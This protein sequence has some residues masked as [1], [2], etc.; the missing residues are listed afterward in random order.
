MFSYFVGNVY[1]N[2][3]ADAAFLRY[4]RNPS[5]GQIPT[6]L[7]AALS[8]RMP[9]LRRLC[10]AAK[11]SGVLVGYKDFKK[12]FGVGLVDLPR[13]VLAFQANAW[14]VFAFCFGTIDVLSRKA[15]IEAALNLPRSQWNMFGNRLMWWRDRATGMSLGLV[16]CDST[17]AP[18]PDNIS[19]QYLRRLYA[20]TSLFTRAASYAGSDFGDSV[21]KRLRAANSSR[22]LWQVLRNTPPQDWCL[23]PSVTDDLLD[24]CPAPTPATAVVRAWQGRPLPANLLQ[25]LQAL[26]LPGAAALERLDRKSF[27]DL[28]ST[29][30]LPLLA[31]G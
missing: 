6:G 27:L 10:L 3:N 20:W 5:N 2:P 15:V 13:S 11:P 14:H 4:L 22:V 31:A 9:V 25:P 30:C 8:D 17:D 21:A 12:D 28:S 7:A 26:P 23:Y 29:N 18:F 16:Y 1:A 19:V 24:L